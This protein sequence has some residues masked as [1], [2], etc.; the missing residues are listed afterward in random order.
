MFLCV[1]LS[2]CNCLS[3]LSSSKVQRAWIVL[4]EKK[5]QY[6]Y[7]E[8]QPYHKPKELLDVNPK[9]LVPVYP[10]QYRGSFQAI[11]KDGYCLYE[12]LVL[13][14]YIDEAYPQSPL[15]PKDPL[16]RARCRLA[17]DF[18]NRSICPSFYKYLQEQDKSKW[19]ALEHQLVQHVLSFGKE[20][21][22]NDKKYSETK[23][24][25]YLGGHFTL[26]DAALIPWY[27]PQTFI[28]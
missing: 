3:K 4:E 28:L 17:I 10:F 25:Y 14:E 19:K 6:Q 20:M 11:L 12:S 1:V 16:L 7:V 13:M 8:I 27:F 21:L 24:S 9:G 23:G 5:A 22:E 2:L 18:I 26:V 15:L